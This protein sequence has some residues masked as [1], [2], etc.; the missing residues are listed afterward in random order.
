MELGLEGRRVLLTGATRG[1]GRATAEGFAREGCRLCL[2][3]RTA[4]ALAETEA[5]LAGRYAVEIDTLAGGHS[6]NPA[7]RKLSRRPSR[8][9]IFSSTTPAAS[10]PAV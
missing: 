8:M 7:Q 1:I 2:V 5:A 3:A 6:A 4:E 10:C 9:S